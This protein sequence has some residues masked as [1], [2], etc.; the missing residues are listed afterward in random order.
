M[1]VSKDIVDGWGSDGGRGF[2][3]VDVE[4]WLWLMADRERERRLG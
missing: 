1:G 2:E 3:S 4:R